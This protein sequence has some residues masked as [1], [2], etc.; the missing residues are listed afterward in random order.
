MA[1]LSDDLTIREISLSDGTNTNRVELRYANS[2]N[3]IQAVIRS[4][5]GAIVLQTSTPPTIT[6]FNKI[7]FKY[8]SGDFALWINGVEVA[9]NTTSF[10]TSGLNRLGLDNG[11]GGENFYGKVKQLQV[12][13]TTD[14]DLAALTS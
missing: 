3:K 6:N 1:A 12:F 13:K 8:K 9:T 11:S 5:G 2:V 4:S 7:A 10:L 14:I